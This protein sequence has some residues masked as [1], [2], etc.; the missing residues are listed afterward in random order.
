MC[1][2]CVT[3][4]SL[5]SS[6]PAP[7]PAELSVCQCCSEAP[8]VI[9]ETDRAAWGALTLRREAG[10]GPHPEQRQAA[11]VPPPSCPHTRHTARTQHAHSMHT[12]CT[13][14][15]HGT[16]TARTQLR[17][18]SSSGHGFLL[19]EKI[20][21]KTRLLKCSHHL[22]PNVKTCLSCPGRMVLSP[23]DAL[24]ASG[25]FSGDSYGVS[26]GGAQCQ[27]RPRGL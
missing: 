10:V 16:H 2:V 8:G 19:T 7:A 18:S 4:G 3:A 6:V 25:R 9:A 13:R 26:T 15:A 1:S 23:G 27:G 22:P 11:V 20:R 14:H 24:R 5:V 21:E 12:A 17:E